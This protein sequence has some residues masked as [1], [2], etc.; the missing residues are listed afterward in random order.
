MVQLNMPTKNKYFKVNDLK[1][2]VATIADE[3]NLT[4]I[5]EKEVLQIPLYLEPD[6]SLGY[7]SPGK[8]ALSKLANELGTETKDWIGAKLKFSFE[9]I[10]V[11]GRPTIALIPKVLEKPSQGSKQTELTERRGGEGRDA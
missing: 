8:I 1:D 5:G 2:K 7:W 3:A 9:Q 11:K 4:K 6:K 10:D